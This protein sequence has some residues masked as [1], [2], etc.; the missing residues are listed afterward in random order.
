MV[1]PLGKNSLFI[2]IPWLAQSYVGPLCIPDSTALFSGI[3][4]SSTTNPF[5]RFVDPLVHILLQCPYVLQFKLKLVTEQK[6][7]FFLEGSDLQCTFFVARF[8][9]ATKKCQREVFLD[10]GFMVTPIKAS[11]NSSFPLWRTVHLIYISTFEME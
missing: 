11:E 6:V 1:A 3:A 9:E 4:G 5:F 10:I 2:W 8:L 7:Q